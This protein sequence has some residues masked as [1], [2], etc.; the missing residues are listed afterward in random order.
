MFVHAETFKAASSLIGELL[1]DKQQ[2]TDKARHTIEQIIYITLATSNRSGK[3]WNTPVYSV[4]TEDYVFYWASSPQS[5]HSTNIKENSE[6]AIVI[7]D[8]SAPSGSGFG[9]YISAKAMIVKDKLEMSNA[10]KLFRKSKFINSME[11]ITEDS[12][13][14]L[15]K[16][17]PEKFWVNGVTKI[18]DRYVDKRDEI[19]LR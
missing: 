3:P 14:R 11:D 9:V 6:V 13:L 18:N 8:S 4:H 1:L 19:S 7:Y 2:A 10:L 15:Y 16:A 5:I 17:I 12:P